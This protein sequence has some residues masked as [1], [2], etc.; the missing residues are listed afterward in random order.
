MPETN[1]HAAD[2]VKDVSFFYNT[3]LE[4]APSKESEKIFAR[5]IFSMGCSERFWSYQEIRQIEGNYSAN[6][7][8]VVITLACSLFA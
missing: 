1:F 8:K 6:S 2:N 3:T 5:C 7:F 4:A